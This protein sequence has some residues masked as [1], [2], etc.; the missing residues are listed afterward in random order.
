M[1]VRIDEIETLF[2]IARRHLAQ[3]EHCWVLSGD[4]LP[5]LQAYQ[6]GTV[7]IVLN[8]RY[9]DLATTHEVRTIPVL[10]QKMRRCPL[11][12]FPTMD[13]G[14]VQSMIHDSD[15]VLSSVIPLDRMRAFSGDYLR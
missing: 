10:T 8:R 5:S 14:V 4:D 11:I 9:R 2:V 3:R 7:S 13:F 15:L 12:V 6:P 1:I